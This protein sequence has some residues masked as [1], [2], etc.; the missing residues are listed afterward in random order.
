MLLEEIKLG[1]LKNFSLYCRG[2]S[3]YKGVVKIE[4]AEDAAWSNRGLMY[5]VPRR[6]QDISPSLR[7][8]GSVS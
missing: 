4:G 3:D 8:P 5:V 2:R 7:W 1:V 6:V